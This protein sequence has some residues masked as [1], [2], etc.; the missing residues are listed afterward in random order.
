MQPVTHANGTTT[1][2]V[3][4]SDGTLSVQDTFVLTVNAVNDAPVI[5]NF[6]KSTN[7][8]VTLT[9]SLSDFT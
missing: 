2:T 9:F 5:V 1:V 3:T 4:V 7:E 8:D 6:A